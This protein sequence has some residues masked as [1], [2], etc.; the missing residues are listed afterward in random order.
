MDVPSPLSNGTG[1]LFE[2]PIQFSNGPFFDLSSEV[3][4]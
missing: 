4:E 3:S 1:E 2:I